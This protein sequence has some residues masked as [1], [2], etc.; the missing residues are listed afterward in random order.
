MTSNIVLNGKDF[1]WF[2]DSMTDISE[3]YGEKF[4]SIYG[5]KIVKTTDDLS[6]MET[7]FKNSL[8]I[9]SFQKD[10][11]KDSL[12]SYQSVINSMKDIFN[13]YKVWIVVQASDISNPYL[14]MEVGD[15]M[16][17]GTQVYCEDLKLNLVVC[18]VSVGNKLVCINPQIVNDGI[19]QT[20]TINSYRLTVGWKE[21]Y[22]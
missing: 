4:V 18:Q 13:V 22:D 15:I 10:T 6:S 1:Q 9:S 7:E 8:G 2:L 11:C 3:T 20:L 17:I 21:L 16:P 5:K 19:Y 12:T 14:F